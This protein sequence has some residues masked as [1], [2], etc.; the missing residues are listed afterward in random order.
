[1]AFFAEEATNYGDMV[2]PLFEDRTAGNEA[3]PPL[4]EIGAVL[5]AIGIDVFLRDTVDDRADPGP[6]AS[7]STHGTWFVRRIKHEIGKVAAVTAGNIFQCFK[8]DVFDAGA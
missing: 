7:A 3:C 4:V 1:M 2:V 6:D 8:F 5:A